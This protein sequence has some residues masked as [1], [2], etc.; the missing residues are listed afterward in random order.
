MGMTCM[1]DGP[2]HCDEPGGMCGKQ[3]G[4]LPSV[5]NKWHECTECGAI[6]CDDCGYNCL[7]GKSGIFEGERNCIR[8]GGR[9][10]LVG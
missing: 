2:E 8:C 5:R 9:T 1:C 6:Y 3:H 7:P 10:R 4:L